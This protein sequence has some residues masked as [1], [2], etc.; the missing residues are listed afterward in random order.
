MRARE[1]YCGFQ[2]HLTVASP[3]WDDLPEEWRAA[4]EGYAA[5]V[6]ADKQQAVERAVLRAQGTGRS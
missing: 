1:H 2:R 6:E 3:S 5:E 4:V